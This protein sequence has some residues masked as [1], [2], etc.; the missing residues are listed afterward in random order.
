MTEKD[1]WIPCVWVVA[2]RVPETDHKRFM[3]AFF[4][5]EYAH[6]VRNQGEREVPGLEW[7]VHQMNYVDLQGSMKPA[8]KE[9]QLLK[10]DEQRIN[11]EGVQL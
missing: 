6:H 8:L 4:R 9:L 1:S 11:R 7:S 3:W 2:A 10:I 5:G